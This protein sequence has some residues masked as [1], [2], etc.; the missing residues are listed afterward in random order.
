MTPYEVFFGRKPHWI[1]PTPAPIWNSDVGTDS[2]AESLLSEDEDIH[3]RIITAIEGRVT[4]QNAKNASQMVNRGSKN[5]ELI[6]LQIGWII[7]LAIPRKLRLAAESSRLYCRLVGKSSKGLQLLS[8]FGE[9]TGRYPISDVNTIESGI[10]AGIEIPSM[11]EIR[12]N[13]I[14]KVTLAKA[15]ALFNKRGTI[16]QAQGAG[17]KRKRGTTTTIQEG[18]D[19]VGGSE[20]E[21]KSTIVIV[22]RKRRVPR[23]YL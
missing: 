2:E 22:P 15:V 7:S 14:K 21:A 12:R 13:L 9:L 8:E 16:S 20:V 10:Q 3:Q 19:E 17:R 4:I 5:K 1:T 18:N 6:A 23:R 11:E